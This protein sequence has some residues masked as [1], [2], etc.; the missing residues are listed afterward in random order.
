[1]NPL[2]RLSP[3]LNAIYELIEELQQQSPYSCV[4]DCCCDH[5]YLGIKI[6]ANELCEKTVFVDQLTHLIEQLSI[7]LGTFDESRHELITADAGELNFNDK[8]RHLVLLAGVGGE[9]SVEIV[10]AIEDRHPA[11]QID[12]IFCPSTSQKALRE[13]LT[14]NNFQQ[15]F[16][17]LVLDNKRYYEILYVKGKAIDNKQ[18]RVSLSCTLWNKD[19]SEHQHYLKKINAPRGSKKN[20]R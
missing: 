5:G 17:D 4:W 15:A 11:V 7:R 16:E 8:L 20:R 18:A 19:N 3:R 14:N 1:M 2:P 6:L 12:Y 10:K 9:T 13:Y